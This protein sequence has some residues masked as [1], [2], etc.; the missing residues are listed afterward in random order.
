[1]RPLKFQCLFWVSLTTF[2]KIH[3]LFFEKELINFEIAHKTCSFQVRHVRSAVSKKKKKKVK[4]PS[5]VWATL[6]K[7]GMW[8]VMGTS[9]THV[10]CLHQMHI[11]HT[12]F[13]YLFWLANNKK[14]NIQSYVWATIMKLG[15]WVGSDGHKYYPCGLLSPNAHIL[16][17]ICISVLNGLWQQIIYA[18]IDMLM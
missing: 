14:S 16:Y 18:I 17:L 12:S 5:S 1:M 10:V 8:V 15:M 13:A 7:L 11:F 3:A 6:M 9:T 2:F 4:Y